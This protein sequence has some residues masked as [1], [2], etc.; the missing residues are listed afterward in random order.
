MRTEYR[1]RLEDETVWLTQKLMA[2]LFAVDVRT[3]S[4]H[5][6]NI[7]A[8]GELDDDSV[9]R[10]FRITAADGKACTT[11]QRAATPYEKDLCHALCVLRVASSMRNSAWFSL[12]D[13]LF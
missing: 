12:S 13:S 10:K 7:F 1:G 8:G 11:N 4:E 3:V 2:S 5:L 6:K 9:V